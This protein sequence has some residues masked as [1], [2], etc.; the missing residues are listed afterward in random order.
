MIEFKNPQFLLIGILLSIWVIL[1]WKKSGKNL[2]EFLFYAVIT[3]LLAIMLASPY[4]KKGIEKIYRTDT[5]VV[6][7]IDHSL[8][9][10]VS[11][12]KPSRLNVA[13]KKAVELIE[14]L[15][16]EKVGIITFSDDV[17]IISYPEF[18]NPKTV[19]KIKSLSL[20]PEGSTDILKAI[21]IANSVFSAKGKI[22][23]L[24]SDGG[25]E[26]L[27]KVKELLEKS[28]AKL[29]FWAIA[30]ERGGKVPKY[31]VISKINK[32]LIDIAYKTGG[33]FQ[34]VSYDNSDVEN[35]YRFISQISSQNIELA[36]NLPKSVDLSPFIAVFI[37][38]LIFLKFALNRIITIFAG[39]LLF[40]NLSYAGEIKG[41]IY[42]LTGNYQKAGIEFS[43]EKDIKNRYNAALS[44]FKAGM[45]DRALNILNSIKT[46]D[47]SVY[48][49]VRYLTA[50][51]YI[52][53]NDFEKAY[54]V[55]KEL[56]QVSPSDKRIEKLYNFT[57]MVVNFGKKPEKKITIVKVKEKSQQKNKIAP[58][59]VQRLNPW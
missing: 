45:Y 7:L 5:E 2:K 50:L 37:L 43:E 14:K 11:D 46:E 19:E 55:A 53:K 30:T 40:F 56:V 17:E 33:I 4:M 52:G 47:I 59:N 49:K 31:N 34:K 39:I 24:L 10:G 29:V 57:K 26:N 51:S 6:V 18:M 1:V 28:G 12:I 8:S 20:K 54:T 3:F 27:Y 22:I 16:K 21:S 15:K 23:I 38:V 48:K 36:F 58:K 32:Q 41:Y 9:M 35:I 44:F 25:D 42:Y 13:L